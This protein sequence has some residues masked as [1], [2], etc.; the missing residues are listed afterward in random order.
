M[1]FRYTKKNPESIFDAPWLVLKS[2][3]RPTPTG[4]P[5]QTSPRP[6]HASICNFR[7]AP[8]T[9]LQCQPYELVE[10]SPVGSSKCNHTVLQEPNKPLLDH[11][12]LMFN[13]WI[14]TKSKVKVLIKLHTACI[15]CMSFPNHHV[16]F[17]V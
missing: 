3:P 9:S 6:I 14:P 12:F 10:A 15:H 11:V 5:K 13:S 2:Q 16:V 1:H 7:R 4:L 8:S 17:R